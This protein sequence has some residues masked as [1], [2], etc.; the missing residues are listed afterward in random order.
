[1]CMTISQHELAAKKLKYFH[2]F[3]SVCKI[4]SILNLL[5]PFNQ[6]F[7]KV[8]RLLKSRFKC[9]TQAALLC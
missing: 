3:K 9:C 7:V 4:K 8:F 6:N 2:L 1:M 5:D